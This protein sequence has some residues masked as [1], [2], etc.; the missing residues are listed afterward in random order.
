MNGQW[1]GRYD[2]SNKGLM[3][4]D[5][6]TMG[7]SYAGRIYAY[8]DN[9]NLPSTVAYIRTPDNASECS[10]RLELRPID[11][12]TSNPALWSDVEPMFPGITFPEIADVTLSSADHT[13]TVGWRT[14]IGTVGH[15]VIQRSRAG[16][17]SEYQP[18]PGVSTWK[19]FKTF[20]TELDFRRFIF[21]GQQQRLRLR[22][23]FHRTG[24]ADLVRFVN[25]DIPT[26]HRHLSSRTTHVFNLANPDENGAFFN[27]VQHHGY[28]TPLLDWTYSPYVAAYFA[29]HR[30]KNSEADQAGDDD[31]V[32]VFVFDYD[33]WRNTYP[34]LSRLAG[35]RP[36]FSVL[37]FIALNNERLTPQQSISSLTNID[38]VESYIRLGESVDRSFL[39]VIDLP[40]KE[41]PTVMKELSAMG[42]TAGSLFPGF[43]GACA[44]LKERM[45]PYL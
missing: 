2:G 16:E 30:I 1:M 10:M 35:C 22:T 15:A 3:V 19:E 5:L 38:D 27:L 12:R 17:K 8:D 13:L 23:T 28:P 31:K 37:E 6:D 41:R 18:L 34:Q 32:R 44:E 40:V 4:V 29:Y 21:R 36:H 25:E 7:N 11:P 14:D 42:I 39:R 26:L 9:A 20:V 45:F 24:R 33:K 43:D